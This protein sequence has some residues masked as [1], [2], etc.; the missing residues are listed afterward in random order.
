M[1]LSQL[2]AVQLRHGGRG[3]AGAGFQDK[4]A[5]GWS[6]MPAAH[7]FHCALAIALGA[8]SPKPP[9]TLMHARCVSETLSS[10]QARL[11]ALAQP[12]AAPW[13]APAAPP[14]HRS[15]LLVTLLR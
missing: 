14:A 13:V 9:L 3:G 1:P 2:A 6:L 4:Y 12:P 15:Q 7:C 5:T 8:P 11:S 10:L